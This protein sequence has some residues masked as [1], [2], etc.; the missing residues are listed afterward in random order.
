[1]SWEWQWHCSVSMQQQAAATLESTQQ[2]VRHTW[3]HADTEQAEGQAG[4]DSSGMAARRCSDE[5]RSAYFLRSFDTG[6][7]T[8]RLRSEGR[9]CAG[10][11]HLRGDLESM[12]GAIVP[13]CARC[14]HLGASCS[15]G[16]ST[17]PLTS[18]QLRKPTGSPVSAPHPSIGS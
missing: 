15:C 5:L 13:P 6:V 2:A 12:D 7:E 8:V 4:G 3:A 14:T 1:L 11:S 10:F 18:S 16:R 9:L 17:P